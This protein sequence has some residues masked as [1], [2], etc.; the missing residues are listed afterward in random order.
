[1]IPI[2]AIIVKSPGQ[3]TVVNDREMPSAVDGQVVIKVDYTAICGSDRIY[4]ETDLM[5]GRTLGHEFAGTIHDPGTSG[6][7]VGQRVVAMEL[8]PC[9]TCPACREGRA[10][11]CPS[12]MKDSPGISMDGGQAEYVAVRQDMV[13]PV[14]ETTSQKLAAITEPVA[15]S[16]HGVR[17]A[18]IRGGERLLVI[19]AGPIG[20][21]TAACAKAKGA[22]YVGIAEIDGRR[23][24]M[25]RSLEFIDQVFDPR[26][27]D[28][29]NRIKEAEP[30]K[31]SLIMECTG[32][33]EGIKNALGI[34]RNGGKLVTL[35]IH[36]DLQQINMLK[37]LLK[38][39]EII[40]SSFF[41]PE[42]FTEVL[43]LMQSDGL[44]LE[45]CITDIRGFS[46]AQDTFRSIFAE[47]D[48]SHMKILLDPN[49][50]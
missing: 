46:A 27:E 49:L 45:R 19:G 9:G 29:R 36:D 33:K 5:L 35:G 12:L 1:M 32:T 42:E 15:V 40:P 3:F 17:R 23:L 6:F 26:A 47:G 22:S 34:I 4:W 48:Y 24:E 50:K 2:R 13:R 10:N 21:F 37:L 44:G 31:F 41:T 7:H 20:V 18:G 30:L 16:Y 8:N 39:I 14:P 11:I 38:E 43:E 25:A 28:Y